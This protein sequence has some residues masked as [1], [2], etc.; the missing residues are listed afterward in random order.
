[1]QQPQAHTSTGP[2][3]GSALK[4]PANDTGKHRP[5]DPVRREKGGSLGSS[6]R[7]RDTGQRQ[8]LG[9]EEG[10]ARASHCL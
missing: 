9:P 2:S 10:V 7:R 3:Q 1:M 6:Y 4:A 5:S 8:K